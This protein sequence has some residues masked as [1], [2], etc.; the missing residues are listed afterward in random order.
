MRRKDEK[1]GEWGGGRGAR[2]DGHARKGVS[3]RQR[4]RE[5]GRKRARE[6]ESERERERERE[7]G[8]AHAKEVIGKNGTCMPHTC[9]IT[10]SHV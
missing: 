8:T 4:E 7:R 5:R 10:H 2:R 9:D 6:E 3:A 1:V